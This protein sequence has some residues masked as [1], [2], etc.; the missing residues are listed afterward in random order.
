MKKQIKKPKDVYSLWD[1]VADEGTCYETYE[2]LLDN[3]LE[4]Y[5]LSDEQHTFFLVI[6]H[7]TDRL[8]KT[9]T[10]RHGEISWVTHA[11]RLKK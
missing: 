10:V 7:D 8:L 11:E 4:L 9:I 3:V 1:V 2:E 5:Y 6:E